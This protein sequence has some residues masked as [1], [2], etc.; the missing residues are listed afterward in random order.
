LRAPVLEVLGSDEFRLSVAE[1][2]ARNSEIPPAEAMPDLVA[3]AVARRD[4]NDAI[5]LLEKEKELGALELNDLFILTYVYCLAGE[6]KKA[7]NLVAGK[8][9]H[10]Q[11]GLVCRLAVGKTGG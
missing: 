2:V 3:G 9:R 11:E 10:N 6:V 5:R 7:E 8:H 1:T 4:L